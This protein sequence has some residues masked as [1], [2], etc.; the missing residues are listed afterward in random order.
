M[1]LLTPCLWPMKPNDWPPLS[2]SEQFSVIGILANL[3][4]C[5]F[6]AP[7]KT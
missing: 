7:K 4:T 6:A 5:K 2:G 1:I 3:H